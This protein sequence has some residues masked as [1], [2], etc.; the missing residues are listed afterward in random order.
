[1]LCDGYEVVDGGPR[2][3]ADKIGADFETIGPAVTPPIW[4]IK[5]TYQ[6]EDLIPEITVLVRGVLME[7]ESDI[8]HGGKANM[9]SRWA[10]RILPVGMIRRK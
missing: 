3:V 6:R 5:E 1:M 4:R 10:K 7:L 9:C 2:R 8:T